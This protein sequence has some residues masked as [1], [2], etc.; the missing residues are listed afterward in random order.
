VQVRLA[1]GTTGSK[2]PPRV[3][4]ALP[5]QTYIGGS[6]SLEVGG[7]KAQFTHVCNAHTSNVAGAFFTAFVRVLFYSWPSTIN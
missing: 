2:A 6:I 3:S 7:R 5:K 4:E 1:P